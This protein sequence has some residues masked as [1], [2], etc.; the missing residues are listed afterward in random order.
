MMVVLCMCWGFQQITI[1][2]AAAGISP[3]MQAGLRSIIATVLL[4]AWARLRRIPL[5]GRDGT[6]AVGMAAGALFA[7]EF[8]FIY[9][10]LA[11]TAASRMVVF[12]YLAPC[13]TAL[14]LQ[15]FVPGERLNASQWTGVALAFLGVAL[16]FADGFGTVAGSTLIGDAFGVIAAVLWAATTVLIR[17]TRLSSANATKTL[18]YQLGFS[19]LVLPVASLMAGEPGIIALTPKVVASLAYQSVIVAFASYLAWFWLL[20]RYLAGRLA[21]F[22]FLTPLFGVAFGVIFLSEPLSAAFLGAALL[23]G[24]G[25]ML[26]NR[27]AN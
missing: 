18:F 20:T 17:A 25:I 15:W 10:G 5:F 6:L 13:L 8:V 11:Y 21:V 2:I 7:A 14:G 9:A 3:I 24:A 23:V 16:A 22:S 27:P 12:I 26:V 1:K 19:A 4:L